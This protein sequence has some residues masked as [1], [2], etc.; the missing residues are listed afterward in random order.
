M[1]KNLHFIILSLII[2]IIGGCQSEPGKKALKK[3]ESQIEQRS[4][5]DILEDGKLKVLTTY[6]ST[7]YFLYRGR[8]MGFEYELLQRFSDYLGV[9]LEIHVSTSIDSLINDLN[10]KKIDLVAHG[11]TITQ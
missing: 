4:L 9:D 10:T 6:S 2:A 5:D 7:S 8:P 3:E 11:L 1:L